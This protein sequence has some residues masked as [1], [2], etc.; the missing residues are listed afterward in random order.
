MIN[1]PLIAAKHWSEYTR[2]DLDALASVQSETVRV[3]IE[4]VQKISPEA[5]NRLLEAF[6]G[7]D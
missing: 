6:E 5:A 4:I 2:G 7:K 3:C 1:L